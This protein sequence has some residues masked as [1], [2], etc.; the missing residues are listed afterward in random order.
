MI[1]V[2]IFIEHLLNMIFFFLRVVAGYKAFV[3][4]FYYRYSKELRDERADEKKPYPLQDGTEL[5]P[6]L[7]PKPFYQV[8]GVSAKI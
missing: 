6:Y 7:T 2:G 8:R 5:W 3:A 4:S 1:S